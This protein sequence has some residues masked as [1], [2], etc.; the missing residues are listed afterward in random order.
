M[1]LNSTFFH[2]SGFRPLTV[3]EQVAASGYVGMAGSAYESFEYYVVV[4]SSEANFFDFS[5]SE[6]DNVKVLAEGYSS[7]YGFNYLYP[8]DNG[9]LGY[10]GDIK[11]PHD[12][13]EFFERSGVYMTNPSNYT[14]QVHPEAASLRASPIVIPTDSRM[15]DTTTGFDGLNSNF[16]KAPS[17]I[18][19]TMIDDITVFEG[20]VHYL[21]DS[22]NKVIKINYKDLLYKV[23]NSLYNT[24]VGSLDL[25]DKFSPEDDS[26]KLGRKN[27]DFM[28]K[29]EGSGWFIKRQAWGPE[30]SG[31][32]PGPE[33]SGSPPVNPKDDETTTDPGEQGNCP[34]ADAI[35]VFNGTAGRS[36]TI[37]VGESTAVDIMYK[38]WSA[39]ASVAKMGWR[40]L[41]GSPTTIK[42]GAFGWSPQI[43]SDAY[44]N[45]KYPHK[46]TFVIKGIKEGTGQVQVSARVLC[47]DGT[48][49]T[50]SIDFNVT[51]VKANQL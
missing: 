3:A 23:N 6:D 29:M 48:M 25:N 43:S 38:G 16:S 40:I 28:V 22:Y 14:T 8:A 50:K 51:V 12:D 21:P 17:F 39:N 15:S 31:L 11:T 24:Y 34:S 20:Y 36:R 27:K 7:L 42:N 4:P 44:P 32:P 26:S 1:T 13:I 45:T 47:E 33:P 46:A 30:P 19:S 10:D 41:S 18:P 9:G 49:K 35:W 37:P 5:Q 2:G